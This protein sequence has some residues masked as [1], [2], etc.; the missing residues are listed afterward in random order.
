[1]IGLLVGI[2]VVIGFKIE[3]RMSDNG[4]MKKLENMYKRVEDALLYTSILKK[5]KELEKAT[6][7]LRRRYRIPYRKYWGRVGEKSLKKYSKLLA[8]YKLS[9]NLDPIKFMSITSSETFWDCSVTSKMGAM[10]LSQIMPETAKEMNVKV[11]FKYGSVNM[12]NVENN[13]EACICY[14]LK[15]REDLKFNLRRE[16]TFKEIAAAYNG[17][18]TRARR[19]FTKKLNIKYFLPKETQDYMEKAQFF[20]D[21][22]KKGNYNVTWSS[23]NKK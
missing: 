5:V 22:Y 17:G 21:N 4:K 16:P 14:Y 18:L 10:G 19:V 1:V 3:E 8:Y 23:K 2:A 20:Y 6:Y 7:K 15:C 11:L 12:Y 9:R 13:T